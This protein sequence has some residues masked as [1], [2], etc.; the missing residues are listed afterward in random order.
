MVLKNF[1]YYPCKVLLFGEYTVLQGGSALSIPFSKFTLIKEWNANKIQTDFLKT[2]LDYINTLNEF[3]NRISFQFL[4]DIEAG[5]YF[6]STIP[7]GYGL[8][9]SGALVAAIYTE[10][11]SDKKT[12]LIELKNE[13][14]ILESFF[15]Q[16]SSGID[17]LT[18]YL[19]KT[20]LIERDKINTVEAFKIPENFTLIDSTKTRNAKSAISIFQEELKDILFQKQLT[21]I[22]ELNN[23]IIHKLLLNQEIKEEMKELSFIQL[24]TFD[25]LIIEDIKIVWKKGLEEDTFYMK[26]CGAG[27]GGMYL[28]YKNNIN[29]QVENSI[30]IV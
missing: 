13:L 30:S 26:L 8:G 18:I 4:K 2:Y 10:Y 22:S 6:K 5:M 14:S 1:K 7:I 21:K 24:K 15:H 9:S 11:I 28:A 16:K 27:M 17:P 12:D 23:Q 29:C 3:K 19:N 25:K 20:I